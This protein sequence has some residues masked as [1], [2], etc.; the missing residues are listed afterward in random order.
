MDIKHLEYIVDPNKSM[1]YNKLNKVK[2]ME[3]LILFQT[4]IERQKL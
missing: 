1:F 4:V 3:T 2:K